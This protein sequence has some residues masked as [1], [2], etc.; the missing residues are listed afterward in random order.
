MEHSPPFDLTDEMIQ[1]VLEISELLGKINNLGDLEKFPRL[2]RI[3]R[4][5]SIQ[6]SL[7]IEN[8]SLTIEEVTAI[9]NGKRVLGPP[10]EIL[11][12]EN[13]I[14]AY[15]E[16]GNADPY[17]I[18]EMLRIHGIMMKGLVGE[19][20]KFRTVNVGVFAGKQ[21]IHA[22]PQSTMV[23]Q[24]IKDLFKWLKTS[25]TPELIRSS[26][27]HYEFEFIH[28]FRDGNG[29]MGR[30]WQTAILMKWN[31]VFAW[32]PVESIIFQRQQEYY[33]AIR[34]STKAGRSNDFIVFM[35]K[36]I[37]DAVKDTVSGTKSHVM[38][39]DKRVGMLLRSMGNEPLSATELMECLDLRSRDALRNNYLRPAME[40]DLIE[41]T[42]PKR[43]THRDQRYIKK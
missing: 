34:S 35:L 40:A 36:A 32:V 31:P 5:R 27:F 25:K 15:K 18:K 39:I 21:L 30:L 11:E 19:C 26:V 7:A 42:D 37:L 6:S 17:D 16:L 20:G 41:M 14:E 1:L 28:P 9:I 2:R 33:N 13:A 4:I 3:S 12:V 22:A 10:N 23:P 29:R 24:L 38:N 43:P 8:N